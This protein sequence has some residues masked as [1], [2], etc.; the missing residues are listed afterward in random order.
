MITVI[1]WLVIA[2]SLLLPAVILVWAFLSLR[3]EYHRSRADDAPYDDDASIW[4]A[5]DGYTE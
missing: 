1:Q 4:V 5:H 3:T 2:G